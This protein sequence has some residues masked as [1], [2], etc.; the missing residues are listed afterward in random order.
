MSWGF[1]G[2]WVERRRDVGGV[3][4]ILRCGGRGVVIAAAGAVGAGRGGSVVQKRIFDERLGREEVKLSRLLMSTLMVTDGVGLTSCC[5]AVGPLRHGCDLESLESRGR[6]EC[7]GC[8]LESEDSKVGEAESET[9]H[10]AENPRA[11]VEF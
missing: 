9:S 10:N 1:R 3:R 8:E 4:V 2:E 5:Y 11:R 6:R 7:K